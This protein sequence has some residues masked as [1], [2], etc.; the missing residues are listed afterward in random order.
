[1]ARILY[2][3]HIPW[4]WIKQRPHFI[5]EGLATTHKVD[6]F[7]KKPNNVAKNK[8]LTSY[9]DSND[10]LR[11]KGFR[12][13]PFYAIPVIKHLPLEWINKL[14]LR[15]QIPNLK[16][17]D[18]VWITGVG[19]WPYVKKIISHDS[20]VIYDCMD[21]MSEFPDIK[22]NHVLHK[23][24]IENEKDL[25]MDANLVFCSANYLKLK[26]FS[27]YHANQDK[28]VVLNNAIQ[29]PCNV[30]G[31]EIPVHI[32]EKLQL[33]KGI[34]NMMYIG[35]ISEWFDFD[36]VC[37]ALDSVKDLNLVLIGPI[38]TKVPNHERIIQIGTINRDYIFD[39]MKLSNVL[40]M[41]FKVNELIKSVNPVKLYE[42][43]YSGKPVVASRYGESEYFEPFVKLYR[44]PDEL[45]ALLNQIE[46][47]SNDIEY[48]NKCREFLAHNTWE[49]R[50]CIINAY[51]NRM[52]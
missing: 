36:T 42:Y 37:K 6:V 40:I 23:R 15:W 12:L 49:S 22:N 8:L 26:I 27:R 25:L 35:A 17:Y 11:I 29:M 14:L 32:Q 47:K 48:V 20:K 51:L 13:L 31:D 16:G 28:A 9:S 19:L 39:F 38:D 43:I 10:N 44:T 41:P 30:D 7:F 2:L 3:M 52:L 46:D 18:V 4:G 34:K 24:T 21:D 45:V 5:A 50:V 1:M 33:V